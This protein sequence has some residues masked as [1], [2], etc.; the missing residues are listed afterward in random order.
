[1]NGKKYAVE[2]TTLQLE[3]AIVMAMSYM[4]GILRKGEDEMEGGE[5][6]DYLIAQSI[7]KKL[8]AAKAGA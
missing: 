5:H 4:D 6:E 8:T 1:M 3:H 7:L 2:L